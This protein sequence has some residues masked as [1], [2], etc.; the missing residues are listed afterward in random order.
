M[1]NLLIELY[2]LRRKVGYAGNSQATQADIGQ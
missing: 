1:A 2:F